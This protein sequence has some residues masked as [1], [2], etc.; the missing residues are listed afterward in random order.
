MAKNIRVQNKWKMKI[1]LRWEIGPT[2]ARIIQR[3]EGCL[4]DP[5]R[6]NGL[7]MRA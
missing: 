6:G 7:P 3:V 1:Q 2:V 4:R 5:M